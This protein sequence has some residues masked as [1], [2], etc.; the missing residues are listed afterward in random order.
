VLIGA[1]W[2][3]TVTLPKKACGGEGGIPCADARKMAKA[4]IKTEAKI[5]RPAICLFI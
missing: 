5:N 2:P 1:G 3:F 4:A